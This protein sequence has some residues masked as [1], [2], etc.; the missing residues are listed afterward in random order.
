MS[1]SPRTERLLAFALLLLQK[2]RP[3][4]R[5][6]VRQLVKDYP[7]DASDVAFE[8]MFERDKEELRSLGVPIE[9][10]P[11]DDDGGLGYR[12]EASDSQLPPIVFTATEKAALNL[13][14]RLWTGGVNQ[15][16]AI[17]ALKK[18]ESVA[19]TYDRFESPIP[20]G[21]ICQNSGLDFDLFQTIETAIH[22]QLAV[23]FP[24]QKPGETTPGWRLVSP[25]GVVLH[26]GTSYLVGH[27]HDRSAT[28]VFRLSR[29]RAL[30]K[31][32]GGVSYV[33]A[34]ELDPQ[35]E[36]VAAL[37]KLEETTEHQTQIRKAILIGKFAPTNPIDSD[38]K[39]LAQA[40]SQVFATAL[41]AQE[42]IVK[43]TQDH[44]YL[45]AEQ[46]LLTIRK[47]HNRRPATTS[48]IQFTR[49]LAIV[50]WLVQNPGVTT[51][52]AAAEFGV[53]EAQLIKD[54]NLAFCTEF[55]AE[56]LTIDISIAS[57]LQVIDPQ[58]ISRPLRFSSRESYALQLGLVQL[59]QH[60]GLIDQA[61]TL[62]ALEKLANATGVR[63]EAIQL[64]DQQDQSQ[65]T[66][67]DAIE[68]AIESS[69]LVELSYQ[70][71]IEPTATS[72]MV[73]PIALSTAEGDSYLIAWCHRAEG[74]RN[75]R[76][77]RIVEIAATN[78]S[79]D[80]SSRDISVRE[81]KPFVTGDTYAMLRVQPAAAWWADTLPDTANV[82]DEAGNQ[83]VSIP[84]GSVDWLCRSVAGFGGEIQIL[85][86]AA[87]VDSYVSYLIW[88][89]GQ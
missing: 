11:I 55:G 4:S 17:H 83:L 72:R 13:A 32:V 10:V 49:I 38:D 21:Y 29:I 48:T 56:N 51:A 54:L 5:T 26:S 18:L 65:A 14:A 63:P 30:P 40:I 59:Q 69:R 52:M 35:T 7:A 64:A 70:G 87:L 19:G 79:F 88:A 2:E 39:P 66:L 1:K 81:T 71:A 33:P 42:K 43:F 60:P 62:S 74:I 8:K 24:Y 50:P 76:L 9:T 75:F 85:K 68:L 16:D 41:A 53:S 58:G 89:N 80:P 86:P 15:F 3:I 61:A 84:V 34:N 78:E 67:V 44:A 45:A 22:D 73:E 25:W 28:R 36:L 37:H 31:M 82:V 6:E 27:D 57:T 77:D 23:K 47:A 20:V 12:L 46:E